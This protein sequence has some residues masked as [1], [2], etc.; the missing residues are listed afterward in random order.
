MPEA[1]K[2]SGTEFKKSVPDTF[3]PSTNPASASAMPP[4]IPEPAILP[5]LLHTDLAAKFNAE[6]DRV[7]SRVANAGFRQVPSWITLYTNGIR[8]PSAAPS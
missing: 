6:D 5:I 2:V 4:V 7:T 3:L 8:A 1:E